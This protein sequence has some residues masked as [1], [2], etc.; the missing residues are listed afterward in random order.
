MDK[1][2][3]SAEP[4]SSTINPQSLWPNFALTLHICFEINDD[5]CS[6]PLISVLEYPHQKLSSES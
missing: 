3:P 4:Q 1:L 2:S 6:K 5:I